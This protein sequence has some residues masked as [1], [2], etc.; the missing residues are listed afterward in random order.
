MYTDHIFL[1]AP[2]STEMNN[3]LDACHNFGTENDI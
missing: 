3:M 1:M 2:I